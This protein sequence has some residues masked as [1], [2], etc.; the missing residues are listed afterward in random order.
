M[1]NLVNRNLIKSII[2]SLVTFGLYDIYWAFRLA[3]EISGFEDE[4]NNG[5]KEIL[6]L[7]F[8]TFFG[9]YTLE[10]ELVTGCE[11]RGIETE[12]HSVLCMIITLVATP[13]GGLALLQNDVNRLL[14]KYGEPE[15]DYG[16]STTAEA[17][18]SNAGT[19][20][21]SAA[22]KAQPAG[23]VKYCPR[24]GGENPISYGCCSSCGTAL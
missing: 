17:F 3:K 23:A 19:T 8:F 21:Q 6:V 10:K 2:L 7:L 13:V 20:R 22:P 18:R 16:F 4:K 5:L 9:V 24:C 1:Q 12:D 14:E 15:R 11:T